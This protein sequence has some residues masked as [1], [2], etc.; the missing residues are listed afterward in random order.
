MCLEVLELLEV[1]EFSIIVRH[2]RRGDLR[3]EL[4]HERCSAAEVLVMIYSLRRG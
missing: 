1:W 2:K 3:V 4:G